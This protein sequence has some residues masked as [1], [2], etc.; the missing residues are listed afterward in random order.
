MKQSKHKHNEYYE[1]ESSVSYLAIII[2]ILMLLYGLFASFMNVI[3]YI[4]GDLAEFIE[5]V[6]PSCDGIIKFVGGTEYEINL[7]VNVENEILN[8]KLKNEN[9]KFEKYEKESINK[10]FSYLIKEENVNKGN[11]Y[12]YDIETDNFIYNGN[13]YSESE[14][15]EVLNE[16]ID[17]EFSE[18][19]EDITLIDDLDI[20]FK[21]LIIN[22]GN[23]KVV[24]TY[25]ITFKNYIYIFSFEDD[26][27]VIDT[28]IVP[29]AY[30][31]DTLV[32][33]KMILLLSPDKE[34]LNLD[35]V[36]DKI[37]Y[38]DLDNE[39][40]KPII[41]I[42]DYLNL[43]D[44]NNEFNWFNENY[45][46][47]YS[48]VLIIKYVDLLGNEKQEELGLIFSDLNNIIYK[49][50][51]WEYTFKIGEYEKK[52]PSRVYIIKNG[53]SIDLIDNLIIDDSEVKSDEVGVYTVYYN[54]KSMY[55][56]IT[57]VKKVTINIVE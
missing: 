8:V 27:S 53:S 51:G 40:K 7:N 28:S 12:F 20:C 50:L 44:E 5:G 52:V 35:E 49:G 46:K 9:V 16:E 42:N 37:T 2:F 19:G 10:S 11:S 56:N 45:T 39:Y 1:E 41:E 48:V 29:K 36:F 23:K 38:L 15:K 18:L 33:E 32:E 55:S 25:N 47:D 24:R 6:C 17:F 34:I 43:I 3:K 22:L 54:V 21:D 31:D 57:F 4:R 14:F 30:Y 13:S 26:L